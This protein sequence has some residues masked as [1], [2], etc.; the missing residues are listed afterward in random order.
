[1][2]FI[3][4]SDNFNLSSSYLSDI[5]ELL[6]KKYSLNPDFCIFYD[7][8]Q[9]NVDTANELGIKGVKF[10]DDTVKEIKKLPKIK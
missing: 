4:S 9:K 6:L 1:M 5:Y 3:L 7:D 8:K 2:L 10:T